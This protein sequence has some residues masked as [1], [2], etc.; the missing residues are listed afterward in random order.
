MRVLLCPLLFASALHALTPD[1]SRFDPACGIQI[2]AKEDQIVARWENEAGEGRSVRFDLREGMPLIADLGGVLGNLDPLVS[3]TLGTRQAPA[4]RPPEMSIWNTFFDNPHKRPHETHRGALTK[5]SVAVSSDGRRAQV[6]IGEVVAGPFHGEMCF[7]FFAGSSLIQMEAVMTTAQDKAAYVFDL[8]LVG[9][10]AGWR[11]LSWTDTEGRLQRRA[12]DEGARSEPLAVRHR[13]IAAEGDAGSV[14][15]FPP[16]HAFFYPLDLTNNTR[17]IWHGAGHQGEPRFGIGVRHDPRGAGNFVPWF[18]APPGTKQRL[19]VFLLL[20]AGA[21]EAALA[22]AR[23]FTRE[24]RFAALPGMTTFTSHYHMA[25][26]MTAKEKLDKGVK[27]LPVPDFVRMFKDMGVQAVHLGEF[28]GDGHQD[29]PGPLRLPEMKLMFDECARLSDD[30]LLVIPGEEI[31]TH[32]GIPFPGRHPGHWMLLFPKPVY[33]TKVRAKD[34]PFIEQH[35]EFGTVYHAGDRA[36]MME[37]IKREGAL[38]WTAHPRIKASSWAPDSFKN[39]DFFKDALWLGAAFKAMPADLSRERLGERCLDLL[40]D[41]CNWGVR[42]HLLG[43]VDVFKLDHTHELY[44]HMNI[45]YLR[46]PRM[47]RYVEGW[48]PVLDVLQRG[49]F[50]TTTGEVL[51]K[52]FTLGGRQSGEV[53]KLPSDGRAE[54]RAEV[55]WTFPLR[56]AEIISGDGRQVF[57]ERISLTGT[58]VFGSRTILQEVNLQGRTWARLEVWDAAINGAWSQPVWLE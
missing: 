8:G 43:E 10:S 13:M 54:L 4:G 16:P 29:D 11:Q 48:Q 26:G 25:V 35:P 5:K 17:T 22:A 40:D 42:K 46:L 41:M 55:E 30:E 56:F 33:W 21:G 34:Q 39:E 49:A 44:G 52:S 19:G 15:L 38:A 1:H 47:P 24:D 50:F 57:R 45:N 6:V 2:E 12:A 37:I 23:R 31:N 9:A 27:P 58:D 32:L 20:N 36:D 3:L 53:L 28:H 18:N 14:A 7:T 51:V